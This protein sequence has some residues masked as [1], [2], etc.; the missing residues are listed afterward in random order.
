MKKFNRIDLPDGTATEVLMEVAALRCVNCGREITKKSPVLHKSF[1]VHSRD[2]LQFCG[3][4]ETYLTATPPQ[5]SP[6]VEIDDLIVA[7]MER[8]AVAEE[9]MGDN[10]PS[11]LMGEVFGNL[12]NSRAAITQMLNRLDHLDPKA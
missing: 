8:I 4:K 9:L 10:A 5:A 7:A 12:R 6:L 2:G 11:Y 3:L 1:Y